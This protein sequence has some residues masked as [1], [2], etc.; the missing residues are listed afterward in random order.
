MSL[1]LVNA[2]EDD[3]LGDDDDNNSEQDDPR[4]G[5]GDTVLSSA[6]KWHRHTVKVHGM[7]QNS[8]AASD[9]VA[10]AGNENKPKWL[11]YDKMS[12]GVS[13]RTAAGVFFE[14]LQLKTWDYIDL[15]QDE[16]Y[17]DIKVRIPFLA[18]CHSRSCITFQQLFAH[19]SLVS[20]CRSRR[21]PSSWKI[22]LPIRNLSV[23]TDRL[24]G[25]WELNLLSNGNCR[26]NLMIARL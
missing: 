19:Q 4:Q 11:S 26:S 23:L 13:R 15:D 21:V 14:L 25:M 3:I 17:G 10:T 12:K 16:S 24:M 22:H 5:A 7:L 8:M 6:A 1:G 18:C 20:L 9:D 2:L